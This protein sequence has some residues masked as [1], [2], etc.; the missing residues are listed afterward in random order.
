MCN[1]LCL[2][3]AHTRH[4]LV[5]PEEPQHH[6]KYQGSKEGSLLKALIKVVEGP[7]RTKTG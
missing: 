4:L 6:I 3:G 2:T 7:A 1:D 5:E